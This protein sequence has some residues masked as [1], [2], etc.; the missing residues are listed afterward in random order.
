MELSSVFIIIFSLVVV[1]IL[2]KYWVRDKKSP[3]GKQQSNR[4]RGP[5]V[6]VESITKSLLPNERGE[7]NTEEYTEYAEG[8]DTTEYK[9]TFHRLSNNVKLNFKWANKGGFEN[10]KKLTIEWNLKKGDAGYV[11]LFTYAYEVPTQ[12]GVDLPEELKNFTNHEVNFSNDVFDKKVDKKDLRGTHQLVLKAYSIDSDV[13][14]TLYTSPLP[15]A[16]DG[17]EICKVTDDDLNL[18]MALVE[19]KNFVFTAQASGFIKDTDIVEHPMYILNPKTFAP[20]NHMPFTKGGTPDYTTGLETELEPTGTKNVIYIKAKTTKS[21]NKDEFKYL[22]W[23]GNKLSWESG[24]SN[25]TKIYIEDFV[26]DISNN[27][28]TKRT[29]FSLASDTSKVLGYD[30]TNKKV[31][32]I[33]YFSIQADMNILEAALWIIK[34]RNDAN[35]K[36]VFKIIY[37]RFDDHNIDNAGM[38]YLYMTKGSSPSRHTKGQNVTACSG[39]NVCISILSN[40]NTEKT[41]SGSYVTTEYPGY[42]LYYMDISDTTFRDD[43]FRFIYKDYGKEST[44]AAEH[45]GF[46]G[47]KGIGYNVLN[48]PMMCDGSYRGH[49]VGAHEGGNS[50][51]PTVGNLGVWKKLWQIEPD[52]IDDFY[53]YCKNYH[54]DGPGSC[55]VDKNEGKDHFCRYGALRTDV[56]P[57]N[58]VWSLGPFGKESTKGNTPPIFQLFSKKIDDNLMVSFKVG[59]YDG[60]GVWK[61]FDDINPHKGAG[62]GTWSIKD[63]KVDLWDNTNNKVM[64]GI[65]NFTDGG[66]IR[67]VTQWPAVVTDPVIVG[68]GYR[69]IKFYMGTS[70]QQYN[71]GSNIL[72]K[73]EDLFE[74]SQF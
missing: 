6:E 26:D 52:G 53:Y 35:R 2:Y 69:G 23:N 4:V 62:S 54:P 17:C 12:D 39:G 44:D 38:L 58:K 64:P 3:A 21:S 43:K 56:I 63:N 16:D 73:S 13:V 9:S 68:E 50:N 24:T 45:E 33:D 66:G 1:Y 41:T 5:Q 11:N 31:T 25:R 18:T 8:E 14:H 74:K 46:F 47:D 40:K 34:Y 37:G 65:L 29:L 10:V 49:L 7:S 36:P 72:T 51:N 15:D 30:K 60:Q 61:G 67:V 71:T 55:P 28:T 19:A 57:F 59:W 32:F 48:D 27:E 42:Q 20:L 70:D 22:Y